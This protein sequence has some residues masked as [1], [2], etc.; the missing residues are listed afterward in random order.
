MTAPT[1]LTRGLIVAEPWME[2]I[3][4][5]A[6]TWE[7]RRSGCSIRGPI[8][9]IRKGSGCVVGLAELAGQAR[10]L[11]TPEA[12]ALAESLHRIPPGCQA[13][14]FVDGWRTPWVLSD[15][16]RLDVPVPYVHRQGAVIW[17]KLDAMCLAGLERSMSGVDAQPAG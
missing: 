17:V 4:A 10:A 12:Y 7:M 8:A 15:V 16:R 3:L 9:L 5:G 2:L 1:P 6:K 11:E 13:R 14:A